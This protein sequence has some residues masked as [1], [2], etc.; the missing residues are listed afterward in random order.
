MVPVLANPMQPEKRKKAYKTNKWPQRPKKVTCHH[1]GHTGTTEIKQKT[2]WLA[3]ILAVV[4][5]LLGFWCGCCLI[6]FFIPACNDIRHRCTH[7]DETLGYYK[8]I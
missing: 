5:F 8:A 2:G 3:I 7:C 1:C 4:I 6:P